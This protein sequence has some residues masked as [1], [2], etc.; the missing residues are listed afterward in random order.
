MPIVEIWFVPGQRRLEHAWARIANG[1]PAATIPL[2]RLGASDCR[3]PAHVFFLPDRGVA[4]KLRE[5]LGATGK[6]VMMLQNDWTYPHR[7]QCST[8]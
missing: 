5:R 3:C 6:P 2:P 7:L 4:Q 8:L 1:F